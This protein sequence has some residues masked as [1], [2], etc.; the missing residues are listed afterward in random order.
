MAVVGWTHLTVYPFINTSAHIRF[1]KNP[2]NV[3]L[4]EI[5]FDGRKL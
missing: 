5:I 3:K 1:H 4:K 2:N